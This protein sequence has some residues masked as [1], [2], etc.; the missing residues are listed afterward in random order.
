[1]KLKLLLFA[2][3]S[4]VRAAT[5]TSDP[6]VDLGYAIHQGA[7]NVGAISSSVLFHLSR[8]SLTRLS[9]GDRRWEITSPSPITSSMGQVVNLT[10]PNPK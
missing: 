8:H 5:Q 2:A 9:R 3:A 10:L 6:I 7:I 4:A 1:M